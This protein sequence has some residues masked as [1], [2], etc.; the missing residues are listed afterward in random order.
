[1]SDDFTFGPVL[2]V[3]ESDTDGCEAGDEILVIDKREGMVGH[4]VFEAELDVVEL[5]GLSAQ[6]SGLSIAGGTDE[7][8]GAHE[9]EEPHNGQVKYVLV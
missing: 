4:E 8:T 1:M 9:E 3:R 5:E 6:P 2:L 7:F